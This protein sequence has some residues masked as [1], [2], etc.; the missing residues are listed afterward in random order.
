MHNVTVFRGSAMI[1]DRGALVYIS[2][3]P[4]DVEVPLLGRCFETI[5]YTHILAFPKEGEEMRTND[6]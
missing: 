6:K 5:F 2:T 4:S 1:L 3:G